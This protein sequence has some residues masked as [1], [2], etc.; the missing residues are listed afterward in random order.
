MRSTIIEKANQDE[1]QN[2]TTIKT[3]IK[4]IQNLMSFFK[5]IIN[6][7]KTASGKNWC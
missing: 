2:Q 5:K 1:Q 3:N 6:K 4:H 7:V